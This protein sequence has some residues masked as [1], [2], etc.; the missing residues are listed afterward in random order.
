MA[1]PRMYFGNESL[2]EMQRVGTEARQRL[3]NSIAPD[4]LNGAAMQ[5]LMDS[6]DPDV[7]RIDPDMLRTVADAYTRPLQATGEESP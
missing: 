7:L 5:R 1:R 4:M 2:A 6:I 3:M